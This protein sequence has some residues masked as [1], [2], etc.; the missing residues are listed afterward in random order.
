MDG[1][2]VERAITSR[3][4]FL[5]GDDHRVQLPKLVLLKVILLVCSLLQWDFMPFGTV[6]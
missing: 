2:L 4:E 3:T 1:W 6:P 5:F